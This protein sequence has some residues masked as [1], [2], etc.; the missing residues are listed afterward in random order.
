LF[1]VWFLVGEMETG[2]GLHFREDPR[3]L[4]GDETLGYPLDGG[5][6]NYNKVIF[7][8]KEWRGCPII[9]PDGRRGVQQARGC[10]AK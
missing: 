3:A 1:Y 4:L 9:W 2:L 10:H 8:E 5:W 6:F 7:G